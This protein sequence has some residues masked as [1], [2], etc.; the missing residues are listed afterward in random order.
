[1]FEYLIVAK[2]RPSYKCYTDGQKMNMYMLTMYIIHGPFGYVML[3]HDL[4]L[5]VGCDFIYVIKAILVVNIDCNCFIVTNLIM[6][7]EAT[8]N[9]CA[10]MQHWMLHLKQYSIEHWIKHLINYIWNS[11]KK[12]SKF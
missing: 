3:N 1:M 6:H 9:D 12:I 11:Y 5:N 2:I 7:L 10:W 8:S 4:W